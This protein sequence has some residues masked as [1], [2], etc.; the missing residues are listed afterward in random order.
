MKLKFRVSKKQLINC[1]I[2]GFLFLTFGN[3]VFVWALKYVDSGFAALIAST[4]PLF[5]IFLMRILHGTKIK[6][7]SLFGV[8]LGIIGMYL[9]VSQAGLFINEFTLIGILMILTCVLSWSYAS[10]FVS[11]ADLPPSFLVST[12][13]QMLAAGIM[14]CFLSWSLGETWTSPMNWSNAAK[15]S[16]ILLII[17]GSIVAFTAFNYLLKVIST[18][19]VA[20]S[21]YVNPVIA[22]LLGWYVLD[23]HISLQS[24]IAAAFLLTGVYFINSKKKFVMFSRFSKK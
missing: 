7:K 17:F 5:V 3:G 6:T 14:L 20:T 2:A 8:V 18:E 21:A 13:Y 9:L 23:E 15:G 19:K 4:Q 11:K 1:I 12:A 16:M 24:I 22:L 10:I